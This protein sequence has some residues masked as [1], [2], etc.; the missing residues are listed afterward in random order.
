MTAVMAEEV[1]TY[2]GE[3]LDELLPQIR[4]ELGPNAVIVRQREG[5]LG[6]IGG[7]FGKRC[8]EVDAKS[9]D[10]VPAAPHPSVPAAAVFD[11]YDSGNGAVDM[12]DLSDEEAHE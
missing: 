5:I 3:T 8:L 12:E 1:R 7:F 6:G 4:E 2:R 11:A 9:L 10:V